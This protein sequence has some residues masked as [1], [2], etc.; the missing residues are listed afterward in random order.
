MVAESVEIVRQLVKAILEPFVW[1]VQRL[2]GVVASEPA[3]ALLLLLAL[4]FCVVRAVRGDRLAAVVL[5]PLSFA[6]VLFNGPIEGPT[7][8][9][10]SWSHGITASDL[11]AVAGLAVA[12]WRLA[13]PALIRR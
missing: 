8:F 5:V 3:F 12:V 10:V 7:L 6:W 2:R 9:V 4:L 13:G 11:I 1:P